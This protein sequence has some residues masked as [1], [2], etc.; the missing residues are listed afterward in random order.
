VKTVLGRSHSFRW[1]LW[2]CPVGK[3][4]LVTEAR[5][6][7]AP[8]YRRLFNEARPVAMELIPDLA[9]QL[10]PMDQP[11]DV[12]LVQF[13]VER[14]EVP[15]LARDRGW[16]TAQELRKLNYCGVTCFRSLERDAAV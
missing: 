3:G 7:F 14:T 1:A 2:Y 15:E 12:P 16:R 6:N 13:W 5:L 11:N 8:E 4:C 10:A 9:I